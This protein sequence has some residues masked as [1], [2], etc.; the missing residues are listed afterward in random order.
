[1]VSLTYT[2]EHGYRQQDRGGRRWLP[3]EQRNGRFQ[4]PARASPT[5][6]ARSALRPNQI[7]P[8]QRMLSSMTPTIDGQ[9]R[10]PPVRNGNARRQDHHQHDDADDPERDRPRHEYR[11]RRSRHQEFTINGCR[12]RHVWK[13]ARLSPDTLRLYEQRGSH[14][15]PVTS[16]WLGDGRVSRSRR[17]VYSPVAPIRGRK[18][19]AWQRISATTLSIGPVKLVQ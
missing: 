13:S 3:A 6:R 4:C 1:M 10:R 11:A 8:E 17:P 15:P 12:I 7:R 5:S 2:L 9:G 19:A 14:H 18:T 16:D